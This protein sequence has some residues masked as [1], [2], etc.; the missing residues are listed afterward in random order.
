MFWTKINKNK[1]M[2]IR[3][4]NYRNSIQ[5]FKRELQEAKANFKKVKKKKY[6][7]AREIKQSKK[8]EIIK[9]KK[10]IQTLKKQYLNDK[11]I[12]KKFKKEELQKKWNERDQNKM[13]ELW[14]NLCS[15]R[16]KI[17]YNK[18]ILNEMRAHI[19]EIYN[20]W[21]E[22]ILINSIK[23][24]IKTNKL[25]IRDND[26]DIIS[27]KNDFDMEKHSFEIQNLNFW[28]GK[29][30]VLKNVTAN[31]KSKK[32]T[33]LIGPSGC[34]KSTFLKCLNRMHDFTSKTKTSGNI[35]FQ[36]KN[37]FSKI[38]PP[39]DLR[40][41]VGMVFQTPTTFPTSIFE[42]VSYSLKCHGISEKTTV[43]RL[44]KEVLIDVALWDEI[45]DCLL[46]P[47]SS[48]SGGQ[49]QR[50]C[51]ARAVIIKPSVLLMDEPTSSL[52][53]IAVT[54]VEQ[55][56]NKLKKNYTIIIVTHSMAQTQRIS[57]ETIFFYNGEII[58]FGP[59]RDFFLNP[60]KQQTKDYISG[61]I[62]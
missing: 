55:L 54:K 7:L 38:L 50:L 23:E 12:Y 28:Y 29:K 60:K 36:G 61:K 1:K 48:L 43:N 49:Q 35:W 21:K 42:N 37:V 18:C 45:K 15:N 25:L 17:K 40:T 59:T 32:V 2:K 24:K 22:F 30:Q 34:G 56:I 26:A 16:Q 33:A 3:N 51:I 44:V 13:I 57:D 4:I 58:E 47:A 10:I 20:N 46:M 6:F 53:P 52:D 27:Y 5:F 9:Q 14:N 62:K 8:T 41:Q 19:G 11:K 31:I 39:R